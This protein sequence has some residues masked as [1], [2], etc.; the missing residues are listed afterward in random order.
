MGKTR[1]NT[2]V[3]A[4]E[5]PE[6]KMRL[7][8]EA[9]NEGRT[10]HFA[11][12]SGSYAVF[13]EQGSSASEMTAAKITDIRSRLP[14]CAGQAEGAVS[15]YIQV[16]LEDAPTFLKNSEV[17]VSMYLDTSTEP[18]MVQIMV[19]WKTQLFLLSGICTV[20]LWQ[21]YYRKDNLRKSYCS[22]FGRMFPNENVFLN[23]AKM[24]FLACVC[25]RW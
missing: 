13:I 15:A 17:R 16:K 12:G 4:D 24:A 8:A 6:T 23:R 19:Q 18:E 25:G 10:V 2:S 9:T 3:A 21:D 14:G 22:T 1:E 20:I 11:Y 7:I 5:S